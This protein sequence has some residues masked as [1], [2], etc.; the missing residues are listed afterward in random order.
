MKSQS[1]DHILFNNTFS[2]SSINSLI[3][4]Y[5]LNCRCE[6][7]STAT[8]TSYQYRLACFDWFCQ[9]NNYPN[10]PRKLTTTHIRQFLWYIASEPK[11][12]ESRAVSAR[13][14]ASASRVNYYYRVLHSFFNWLK[15]EDLIEE[16]PLTRMKKRKFEKRA[17]QAL[18]T[19]ETNSPFSQYSYEKGANRCQKLDKIPFLSRIVLAEIS[20]GGNFYGWCKKV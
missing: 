2:V 18:K 17:V 1:T 4:G 11:R 19:T 16:N 7:K 6:Q 15:Q 3:E 13:K 9:A 14:P 5:L 12:W 8:V 20:E 10:E